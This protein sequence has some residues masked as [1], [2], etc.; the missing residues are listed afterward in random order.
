[1]SGWFGLLGS[2]E[3]QAWSNEVDAWLLDRVTG[4]GR[5]LVVPTAS[6]PEGDEVFS[7]WG[8][9]GLEHFGTAGV[10]AEVLDVRDRTD[11]D[12]A[13]I[14]ERVVGAS[15][16]YFSGGNPAYLAASLRNT[17]LWRTVMGGLDRGMGYIGCSAGMACLGR[18]A[19]D[20]SVD[21]FTP[22]LW[23]E[24]LGLFPRV[25][26]GPHWD[27]LDRFAPGLVDHITSTVPSDELLVGVD[28][29]TAL[30]GDGENW[31]VIGNGGVHMR[32]GD[33]WVSHTSPDEV[34]VALSMRRR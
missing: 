12:D 7:G 24:G 6:A 5:V 9:S 20:S 34:T 28:E 1:M 30:V 10:R 25:W 3:F 21:E 14:A 16:V 19:P 23:Q 22:E 15:L 4:D 33:A 11:A 32:T 17:A 13:M 26:F 27:V 2:G 31:R 18:R 29:Q 8:Q